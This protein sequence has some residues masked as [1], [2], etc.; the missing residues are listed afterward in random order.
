MCR[1][2]CCAMT[3]KYKRKIS[4]D[5]FTPTGQSRR[6]TAIAETHPEFVCRVL[7]EF[8]TDARRDTI[9]NVVSH[10]TQSLHVAVEGLQDPH[11]TAAI[12]RTAD[13]FGVQNIHIIEGATRFR[14]SASVT[15]GAHKWIDIRIH[16]NA[17]DFVSAMKIEGRTVL[18]AAMDGAKPVG[19]LTPGE[20]LV[21][22]FGNESEGI[23]DEMR[24]LADGAFHI[25]MYGFV[26]SFNVSVAAAISISTLRK[27]GQ[28][29]FSAPQQQV[30]KARYYLRSVRA[31]YDILAQHPDFPA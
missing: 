16:H 6:E 29:D 20:Q 4:S 10:R 13:A 31:A 15:Q 9:E 26:E 27:G 5:A 14:S 24:E 7:E 25:P 3:V 17:H 19:E 22:V 8:L 11:N 23:T 12:I 1:V 28:G 2:L 18:V 30:L 21:L